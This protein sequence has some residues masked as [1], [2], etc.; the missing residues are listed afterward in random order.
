MEKKSWN[1]KIGNTDLALS[2]KDLNFGELLKISKFEEAGDTA[3]VVALAV[4]IAKK[5]AEALP[6]TVGLEIYESF[7]SLNKENIERLN[8]IGK[9]MENMLMK[10][11]LSTETKK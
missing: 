9:R 4:G 5:D 2:V 1:V 3:G 7:L 10:S 11:I 8:P 6:V